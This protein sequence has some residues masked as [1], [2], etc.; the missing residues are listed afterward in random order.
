MLSSMCFIPKRWL[1]R[2]IGYRVFADKQGKISLNMQQI[3]GTLLY[4]S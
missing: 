1:E 4:E 3:N 2:L